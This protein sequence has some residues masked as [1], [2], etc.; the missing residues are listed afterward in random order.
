MCCGRGKYLL[1]NI[2]PKIDEIAEAPA[3]VA[4]EGHELPLE[5]Q[6]F[7]AKPALQGLIVNHPRAAGRPRPCMS[8]SSS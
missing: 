7:L 4:Q 2:L 1:V 8:F 5:R 3:V 6:H